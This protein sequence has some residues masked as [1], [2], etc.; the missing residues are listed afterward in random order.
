MKHLRQGRDNMD[1]R[2][3]TVP[4]FNEEIGGEGQ[5]ERLG[6]LKEALQNSR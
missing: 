2:F 4:G 3:Q 5:D 1:L 6:N